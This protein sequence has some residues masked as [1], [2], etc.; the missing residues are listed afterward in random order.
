MSK[1]LSSDEVREV[2]RQRADGLS[3][4]NI[5]HNFNVATATIQRILQHETYLD[6]DVPDEMKVRAEVVNVLQRRRYS[7]RIG[8]SDL[9]KIV[10][11]SRSGHTQQEIADEI[12]VSQACVSIWLK[13]IRS[14]K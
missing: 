10:S 1:I 12:G 14:P 9:G 5:A 7:D 2:W 8:E 4:R 3:L 6:V 11:M 13:R